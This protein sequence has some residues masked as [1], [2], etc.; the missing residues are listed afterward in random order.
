MTGPEWLAGL[1]AAYGGRPSG[2][3]SYEQGR[4]ERGEDIPEMTPAELARE[5]AQLVILLAFLDPYDPDVVWY[6]SRRQWIEAA[7]TRRPAMVG[8]RR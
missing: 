3:Q 1:V 6:E 8:T 7:Q 2:L 4:K 5:R